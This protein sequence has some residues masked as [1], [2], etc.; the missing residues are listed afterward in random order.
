[1]PNKKVKIVE[2]APTPLADNDSEDDESI[3]QS[4]AVAVPASPV[5]TT[6]TS[7]NPVGTLPTLVTNEEANMASVGSTAASTVLLSGN[8]TIMSAG[9]AGQSATDT[10]GLDRKKT[11]EERK[12]ER[13]KKKEEEMLKKYQAEQEAKQKAAAKSKCGRWIK[14]NIKIG[15]GGYKFVYRGYDCVEARNVAWCEFKAEHV[16]TKEKRQAMY[17]ETEIMLKM[18]HP[19]IVRCF[20]VFREWTNEESPDHPLE[21][22]GIVIIQEL[23]GEGTLKSVIRKNFLD[24]QCILKFPL[25][26][27]WWHQI[28]D[29]LRYMHHKLEPPILHRDLKAE[30]CFLYGASDEEYLNVKVGDFGLATHVGNSGRKTMLGTLGFMAPEI[31]DEKY[32]EKVDIYA[33]GMLMLEVM[34]NRTPYDECDTMIQVAA[35][36]MSGHGPDLMQKISNPTVRMVISAC[37]HPLACFRPTAEELYF[38]P[39][40]QRYQDGDDSWPK[41]LP[42]EVETNY[43]KSSDRAEVIERFV[44]S[45]ANPK[46]RNP[47][48]NLRLRFRDKKMLQEL[49]LDDGES[50]EFDLDIYKAEDQDIPDLIHNLRM[51]Y[52][53][54]LWKV[55]ENPKQPDKKIVSNHLDKLFS[56]IRL[57]MQ[58]LVK[59][60][61]GKRWKD[62]LDSLVEK[63]KPKEA[64]AAA[65][66]ED[67][68]D[69]EEGDTSNF[70]IIGKYK[71]KWNRAKKLLEREIQTYRNAA[72]AD[73]SA[74]TTF[75]TGA[76]AQ[77]SQQPSPPRPPADHV[78]PTAPT[79]SAIPTNAGVSGS[80][81]APATG[82]TTMTTTIRETPISAAPSSLPEVESPLTA[83]R[84]IS[85]PRTSA[86][87]SAVGPTALLS[88]G[89]GVS[90]PQGATPGPAVS[91]ASV[92]VAQSAATG[93]SAALPS[94]TPA[95]D[96]NRQQTLVSTGAPG[97]SVQSKVESLPA[98][99]LSSVLP[100]HPVEATPLPVGGDTS[101]GVGPTMESVL[102]SAALI[103][104]LLQQGYSWNPQTNQLLPPAA[105][106]TSCDHS[107]PSTQPSSVRLPNQSTAPLK[108]SASAV[109]LLGTAGSPLQAVLQSTPQSFVL[110][111]QQP[112]PMPGNQTPA[113]VPLLSSYHVTGGS[114]PAHL[115]SQLA[116]PPSSQLARGPSAAVG[117]QDL[118]TCHL[119]PVNQNWPQ[120]Q[121]SSQ[122]ILPPALTRYPEGQEAALI[123]ALHQL[124]QTKSMQN[125]L[126]TAQQTARPQPREGQPLDREHTSE[127]ELQ[128]TTF[129][130]L[131]DSLLVAASPDCGISHASLSY[132]ALPTQPGVSHPLSTIGSSPALIA[133]RLTAAGFE[134]ERN[135]RLLQDLLGS[136]AI[137]LAGISPTSRLHSPS[138][139]L[140][141]WASADRTMELGASI[142][143][144]SADCLRHRCSMPETGSIKHQAFSRQALPS[145]GSSLFSS[146]TRLLVRRR[147]LLPQ[148]PLPPPPPPPPPPPNVPAAR[149]FFSPQRPWEPLTPSN[150][151]YPS[152]STNARS[153]I[154]CAVW[155]ASCGQ[156][157][158]YRARD[159][160]LSEQRKP[161]RRVTKPKPRYIIRITKIERESEGCETGNLRPTFY[162]EMPDLNNPSS[163]T[164]KFSFRCNLS[165]TTDD[166]KLFQGHGYTQLNEE[167]DRAIKDA[168]ARILTALREDENSIKLNYDYVFYPHMS[169]EL[170]PT[171]QVNDWTVGSQQF[172]TDAHGPLLMPHSAMVPE[173][174][175]L[176][177]EASAIVP[178][179][180]NL[181][182]L[183]DPSVMGPTNSALIECSSD[184]DDED[185]S[186]SSPSADSSVDR[187][188]GG[189][190]QPS[191]TQL[192]VDFNVL[193]QQQ[194]PTASA[195]PHSASAKLNVQPQFPNGLSAFNVPL[196]EQ[197]VTSLSYHSAL[198]EVSPLPTNFCNYPTGGE[199]PIPPGSSVPP[200]NFI[201]HPKSTHELAGCGGT[202]YPIGFSEGVESLQSYATTQYPGLPYAQRDSEVFITLKVPVYAQSLLTQVANH[203]SSKVRRTPILVVPG[204]ATS[205]GHVISLPERQSVL[206]CRTPHRGVEGSAA[207]LRDI[208]LLPLPSHHCLIVT[209]DESGPL[210]IRTRVFRPPNFGSIV[211]T[212]DE[213]LHYVQRPTVVIPSS[214]TTPLNMQSPSIDRIAPTQMSNQSNGS[215]RLVEVPMSASDGSLTFDDALSLMMTL[216]G[217]PYATDQAPPK[218]NVTP[219][220]HPPT[221]AA[222][223]VEGAPSAGTLADTSYYSLPYG[224]LPLNATGNFQTPPSTVE[225]RRSTVSVV[226]APTLAANSPNLLMHHQNMVP[227]LF[228]SSPV[229]T[230]ISPP[231]GQAAGLS[232]GHR[233]N[234]SPLQSMPTQADLTLGPL[235]GAASQ[236]PVASHYGYQTTLGGPVAPPPPQPLPSTQPLVQLQTHPAYMR[237]QQ[238]AAAPPL[239]RSQLSQVLGS[240]TAQPPVSGMPVVQQQQQQN[241]HLV[242]G[243]QSAAGTYNISIPVSLLSNLPTAVVSSVV[244]SAARL[245]PNEVHPAMPSQAQD[246]FAALYS[247][248]PLLSGLPSGLWT[249]SPTVSLQTSA[250]PQW[251]PPPA[252]G[253]VGVSLQTQQ[254]PAQIPPQQQLS[255]AQFL[256]TGSPIQLPPPAVLA[257]L[258]AQDQHHLSQLLNLQATL[259]GSQQQQQ[260][261]QQAG[262]ATPP[263]VPPS[264]SLGPTVVPSSFVG[265]IGETNQT[266]S[267]VSGLVPTTIVPRSSASHAGPATVPE[268]LK[269]AAGS[270]KFLVTP[271]APVTAPTSSPH[272]PSP[273][274]SK[275][276]PASTCAPCTATPPRTV[277]SKVGQPI[278]PPSVVAK[279]FTVVPVESGAPPEPARAQPVVPTEQS[280]VSS[281]APPKVASKFTVSAVATDTNSPAVLIVNSSQ[282]ETDSPARCPPPPCTPSA[283][284]RSESPGPQH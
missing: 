13:E 242:A 60:L 131:P 207:H 169:P 86:P 208:C 2:P 104:Q 283:S 196:P 269:A 82:T 223:A 28:L 218:A 174:P 15:E 152:M 233:A 122:F 76:T 178:P 170:L 49:G 163:E 241:P 40:F 70:A 162:L 16:D 111:Q 267:A 210:G 51:G 64:T 48:F 258:S 59:C 88:S 281:A 7:S 186:G 213:E 120:Q 99:A 55:F 253:G 105:P 85:P 20:D 50:L 275:P 78:P 209:Q 140:F 230:V 43:D 56:S 37:I 279:K 118:T 180:S 265:E 143:R 202:Q 259:L 239:N 136:N 101:A 179:T 44:R 123:A 193:T 144:P 5:A 149:S 175:V 116:P 124:Q 96:N 263:Q 191:V 109:P 227:G 68:S 277:P 35:K 238:T 262:T 266:S 31:F 254:P 166:I 79:V 164:W 22:K 141:Q 240:S 25:I 80:T 114:Q 93:T 34:T 167:I 113:T 225:N 127:P 155:H 75:A 216:R 47:K 215:V 177:P 94:H 57:Q 8:D 187:F 220:S 252:G 12:K 52:E 18:N 133:K 194:L 217:L 91:T 110:Q 14:H 245:P 278:P 248:P 126:P 243:P 257:P 261:P 54:K 237:S 4:A 92:P 198:E 211:I 21:E 102:R 17:R 172:P 61:L 19:H 151:T 67:E 219:S 66:S 236:N 189:A 176:L 108:Q 121:P 157:V 33:F 161:R 38:H 62:I 249:S 81:Q 224:S 6:D 165:D 147:P 119:S 89:S 200:S 39:L 184:F 135:A 270:P 156:H 73:P 100:S 138:E 255:Q 72:N 256:P 71:G 284:T 32:D 58:F 77:T 11:K 235:F 201:S 42:V 272:P 173:G 183:S 168:V 212:P 222:M 244:T 117:I 142:R 280:N 107:T 65:D 69:T 128:H 229:T 214:P 185:A 251:P 205:P 203:I 74:E 36:T 181:I 84:V 97:G 134:A 137:S 9:V 145:D 199:N 90:P 115:D 130:Q 158:T 192:P 112:L 246:S 282:L 188:R 26:T 1:M 41:T 160:S 148:P 30:N 29:A 98:D 106:P 10:A 153:R 260:H 171:K 276:G 274:A 83:P 154:D 204:D 27:R 3:S 228:S 95:V 125:L 139:S 226:T 182:G 23:M 221:V 24:G 46:T 250:T 63:Q 247:N 195:L 146:S 197:S 206:C 232:A 264:Q 129:P 231:S 103:Q 273:V 87:T 45:L 271:V 132:S 53:D 159:S 150:A 234:R 190:S 268:T